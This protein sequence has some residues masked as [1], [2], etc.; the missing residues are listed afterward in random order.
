MTQL[1][2]SRDVNL[3]N[4]RPQYIVGIIQLSANPGS[5]SIYSWGMNMFVQNS[6][7]PVALSCYLV[8][9]RVGMRSTMAIFWVIG[10]HHSVEKKGQENREIKD[11]ALIQCQFWRNPIFYYFSQNRVYTYIHID[12]FYLWL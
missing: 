1:V 6:G 9:G 8:D 11:E 10:L 2:F 4:W 5:K 3:D 12:I 7:H